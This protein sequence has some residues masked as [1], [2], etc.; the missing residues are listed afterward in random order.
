MTPATI[1]EVALSDATI[2]KV[3][4]PHG[5][6]N[7]VSEACSVRGHCTTSWKLKWCE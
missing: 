6:S 1:E 4:A 5:G 7:G 3:R 2:K